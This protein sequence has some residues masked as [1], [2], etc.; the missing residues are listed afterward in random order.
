MFVTRNKSYM[1]KI[2]YIFDPSKRPPNLIQLWFDFYILHSNNQH[3]YIKHWA[4][5]NLSQDLNQDLSQ[6]K[7]K[8]Q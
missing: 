3:A 8:T 4:S 2:L 7:E 1:L 6:L 5:H